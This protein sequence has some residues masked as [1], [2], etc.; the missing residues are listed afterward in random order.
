MYCRSCVCYLLELPGPSH[1]MLCLH[2]PRA[3]RAKVDNPVILLDLR[4]PGAWVAIHLGHAVVARC[5]LVLV[6]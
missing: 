1:V 4:I 5:R 2:I 3:G 6:L